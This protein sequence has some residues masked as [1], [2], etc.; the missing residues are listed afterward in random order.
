MPPR[1]KQVG[2]D[3]EVEVVETSPDNVLEDKMEAV[4]KALD[5]KLE[6]LD[7]V[8]SVRLKKLNGAG[9]FTID[10]ILTRGEE[11]LKN[12][13]DI[14]WDDA[15]KM[16]RTARNT[17]NKGTVFS[18]MIIKGRDFHNYR[19]KNI[20][21]MTTG[22]PDLDKIMRGGYETGVITELFGAYGSGKTQFMIVAAIMAQLPKNAC[23]LSC[24]QTE[25]L[26]K[27]ECE[28]GGTVWQGGGLSEWGK[29]IRVVYI[30]TENS[31]RTERMFEIICNRKIIKTKPQT[32][33]EE[34]QMKNREPLNEEEEEKA[35][36][37]VQNVDYVRPTTSALQMVVVDQLGAMING[38]FCRKC[39]MREI[40]EGVP[41][42]KNHPQAKDDMELQDHDFEKDVPAG[43]VIIDSIIAEFRKDFAGRGELS[44][45]QT[46]LKNHIK[47]LVRTAESKNVVCLITNQVMDAVGAMGDPT[48]PVGGNE[49][50][51]TS[52]HRI[53]L[54]KPQSI[55]K[56]KMIAILVDS[57]NN[58][59][60][61]VPFELG[62]LGIQKQS[63]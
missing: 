53:Y 18:K 8:G 42:H 39:Q 1:K 59:K 28:C 34:K 25:K 12:L 62:W 4:N 46:M 27:N 15:T 23:C 58:A 38:D 48:R 56:D 35:W 30:D 9:I 47:R 19:Q 16:V 17:L 60:N 55:T 2:S 3:V 31:F 41:T 11:E 54:K 21:Y 44:D 32:K 10:D 45:R 61:E 20:K 51:H 24:G 63:E 29:P 22:L 7:G 37:F 14:T 40:D 6:D 43:V 13:L 57:P 26:E 33:T 50:G 52:T 49:I 5:M 36:A